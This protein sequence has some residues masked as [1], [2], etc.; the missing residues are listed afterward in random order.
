MGEQHGH[1][2]EH[3]DAARMGLLP[4][5]GNADNDVTEDVA[6]ERA[7]LALVHRESE[8]V[9]RAVFCAIDLVQLV[10]HCVIS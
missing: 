9:C 10:H 6:G 4:R 3:L 2:V 5:G 7:E 1:L 8:H